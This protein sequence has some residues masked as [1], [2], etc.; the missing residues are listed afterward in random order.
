MVQRYLSFANLLLTTAIIYLGVST[1]YTFTGVR[2]DPGTVAARTSGL[3]PAMEQESIAPLTQYNAIGE[4]NLFNV[5][6]DPDSP[7]AEPEAEAVNLEAL[8]ETDLKLKLWGTVTGGGEQSYAVIEDQKAREQ[9]LYR[10]GDT[11][12]DATVKLILREKV[13]LT[14]EGRD[15]ILAMEETAS[16]GGGMRAGSPVAGAAQPPSLP[17]SPYTRKVRLPSAQVQE[18]MQNLGS[19]MQQA[20]IRPHIEDG[21]ADGISITA[22]KPNTIFRHMRLR[23]GDVITGVNGN[24]VRSMDDAIRV[25]GDIS[26]SNSIQLEIK[27]R[28]R[29]QILDY[30]IE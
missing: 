25:F 6:T 2:L 5:T 22:I 4:R 18:A 19:I 27:R 7:K 8:K 12:Q 28:G 30:Q 17:V 9:N 13:V 21:Q 1:F 14:V 10:A 29:S 20:T 26:S 3:A 23:N 15:E 11:I 24:P 16:E